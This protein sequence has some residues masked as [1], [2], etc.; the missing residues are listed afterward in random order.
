[1][2]GSEFVFWLA[3]RLEIRSCEKWTSCGAFLEELQTAGNRY[4]V[5]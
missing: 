3:F 1:M 2:A 5:G 4:N